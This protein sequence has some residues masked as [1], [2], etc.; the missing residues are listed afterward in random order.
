[1]NYLFEKSIEILKKYQDPSGAFIASPNFKVYKYCWFRDGT[2]AAYALDLVGSHAA[3][4]KFYLWCAAAIERYQEKIECIERKLPKGAHLSSGDLLHTRY[5]VDMSESD[6]DW[7]TFQLDGFGAFLWGVAQHIE[8]GG[9]REVLVRSSRGIDLTIQYLSLLW[10]RPCYDCWE[11]FGDK[12]H[13]STLASIY[14]GLS[15]INYFR[16]DEKLEKLTQNIKELVLN[17]GARDGHLVKFLGS[18]EVDVSLLWA[19]IPFEVLQ[20]AHP[21]MKST[22]E[23]IEKDLRVGDGGVHRYKGDSFYGGGEWIILTAWLGWYYVQ[24]GE[25]ERAR[26][27]KSWIEQQADEFGQLPEQVQHS[28][29]FPAEYAKWQQKWGEVAKPLLWSHALYII[30]CRAMEQKEQKCNARPVDPK[31]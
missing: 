30:L 27:I 21:L 1:V 13:I 6:D 26:K 4:E 5:N 31:S 20:P 12:I 15:K 10:D 11:E 9:S 29:N 18:T 8:L 19:S 25:Y 23:K 17:R 22:V 14:G 7:P 28:L 2:Y 16:E 3:A 24:I